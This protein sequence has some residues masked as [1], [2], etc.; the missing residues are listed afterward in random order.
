MVFLYLQCVT[1]ERSS[2]VQCFEEFALINYSITEMK[3]WSGIHRMK[4][5]I[6]CCHSHNGLDRAHYT[7]ACR[8]IDEL[9]VNISSY[10]DSVDQEHSLYAL[11]CFYSHAL[12]TVLSRVNAQAL[13]IIVLQTCRWMFTLRS[14]LALK[15]N[16][17]W[18]DK[19]HPKSPAFRSVGFII[20]RILSMVSLVSDS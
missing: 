18:S 3:V 10:Y 14:K 5:L 15:G 8:Y 19:V 20:I 17:I 9:I 13:V 1:V 6:E 2:G 4:V 12:K 16:G 11:R 7:L